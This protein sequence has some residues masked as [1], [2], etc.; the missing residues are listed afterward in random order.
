MH[1]VAGCKQHSYRALHTTNY[2][3]QNSLMKAAEDFIL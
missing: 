3:I 1:D 2:D